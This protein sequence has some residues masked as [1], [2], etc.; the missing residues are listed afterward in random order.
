METKIKVKERLEGI[1]YNPALDKYSDVTMFPE[2]V[3]LAKKN[4]EG[5][6]LQK[7]LDD[8]DRNEITKP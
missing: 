7:E 3:S 4:L 5:R 1:N 2:K 8:A 6:N